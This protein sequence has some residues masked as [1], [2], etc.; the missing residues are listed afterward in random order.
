[1]ALRGDDKGEM[2][3]PGIMRDMEFRLMAEAGSDG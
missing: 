1:M 3:G 2:S